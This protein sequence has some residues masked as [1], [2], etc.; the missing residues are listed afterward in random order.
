MESP[1]L[2]QAQYAAKAE[3]L[4]AVPIADPEVMLPHDA[5]SAA[6]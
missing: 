2:H 3:K 6:T 1:P 4:T 5:H